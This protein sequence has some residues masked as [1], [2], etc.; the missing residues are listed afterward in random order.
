M[1]NVSDAPPSVLR[2]GRAPLIGRARQLTILV[3][4]LAETRTGQSTVVLL[5]GAPG[6][7]KTRL[8]E[9]FPPPELA[10][11]V[12]V[13]RG[14]AS[15][16][17]GMPPY[18]PF[19]EALGEYIAAAPLDQLRNQI[20]PQAATLVMLFP[21]IQTRLGPLPLHHSLSPEQERFRLYEAVAAF[22]AAI[23]ARDPVV[24]LLDDLQWADAA[25]FDLLVHIAGRLRS[26]ALLVVGAYREGEAGENPAFVRALTELNRRRRLITLPLQPLEAEESQALAVNLLHG[27][28][29]PE[30][31]ALLHG[32][33]EGN[34][35]F[36]E[37]LLRALVEDGTLVW[38]VGSWELQHDPG[39]L[40]PPRVV[41]AIQ[42][43]LTRLNPDT[44]EL[45]RMAA[46]VGRAFEPALLAQIIQR[47]VEQVEEMLLAAAQ[48]QIVRPE[49]EGAYTFVH[50]LVRETLYAEVGAARR[51]R[52]HQMIGEALETQGKDDSP[53]RLTDLSFHFAEAGD[54]A[55]GVSYALAAGEQALRASAAVEAMAYYQTAVRLLG[56]GGD[57]TRRA[58]ALMGL[59]DA[60][61][62]A[63]D[64][65]QA[66]GAYQAAQ[67]S[68]LG[69]GDVAAAARAWE[70][71]GRVQWRQEAVG[72][73]RAAF[74][75]ALALLEPEDSS[76]VAET[77]LQLADLYVTSLFQHVE[78]LAY[79]ERAL[80]MVERLDD[81]WLEAAACCV[82]GNIKA[83]S[84]DLAAGQ[85]LL[86]R[87]LG[88][89]QQLNDPA[90]AAEA[91]AYLANVHAWSGDLN[92]SI[93]VSL[94]RAELARR[95]QD[96]FHLRH[97]YSWIGLQETLRGRW[98][99][100]AQFFTQQEQI[101]ED[102]QSPEPYATLQWSRGILH[103]YQ[104]QFSQAEQ[105]FREAVQRLQPTGSDILVWYLG[106]WGLALAE[107]GRR[108]EALGCF[109]KLHT[110][111]ETL[112][113]RA[114]ARGLAFAQLAVGYARLG[115]RERVAGCY[116]TL[117]PFQGQFTPILVDR[118]LGLAAFASGHI[119]SAQR[120][121][122]DAEA[123]ARRAGIRPELAL[124]LLQRG[125]LESGISLVGGN[126]HTG[127]TAQSVAPVSGRLGGPLAEGL[128]L[129]GEI[130]M[131]ELARRILNSAGPGQRPSRGVHPA[132]LTDR[133]LEVLRLVAQGSTN[134]AIAEALS[135]SEKTVARHLTNI[136]NKIGVENRAGA[137][138]YALRHELA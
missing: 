98:A 85:A 69:N 58:S 20:G 37:E 71:L 21:E 78:G 84:N 13:L 114:R 56:S 125:L 33:S 75:Q 62:L 111:A 76:D 83:R 60:A 39:K 7:G 120:H 38:Q 100:A 124:T 29:E 89:A 79:A 40:L 14:G 19:L 109:A 92:R 126:L 31:A 68:W 105:D 42:M 67:E 50:D 87:G 27:E 5:A 9:E 86:E 3:E 119:A 80:A 54:K 65:P 51:R 96:L 74:E 137:T 30:V 82:V 34:P 132:G 90:L 127:G 104:G 15:Q 47:D 131:Q 16:A 91:C 22:L 117:L 32:Q 81:R 128:R 59:G 6:I 57:M 70:R 123:Q 121:L 108:D 53:Q 23:A 18:L 24:L 11:A 99:E 112:D 4:H 61:T 49:V 113:E 17:A 138:A 63:G 55:R 26:S 129:C 107:L 46:V 43:R 115:E 64:Y 52:L 77:L 136:F 93:E 88:L 35:F 116:S 45:L 130:G 95:T 10:E 133:E 8:L 36:I 73:A 103:Y 135:L 122:V 41:E 110:L 102:L 25:T 118:G 12:T 97:V 2:V 134:R 101:V 28:L 48:A 66:A 72:E 44:V 106:W 1:P 94:L